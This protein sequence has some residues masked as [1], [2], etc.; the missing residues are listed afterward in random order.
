MVFAI[1]L[2]IKDFI[3]FDIVPH[4]KNYLFKANLYSGISCIFFY[5]LSLIFF[6]FESKV[7]EN[8]FRIQRKMVSREQ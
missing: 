2:F 7:Y 4:S 3:Y 1:T 6:K 8:V 5:F